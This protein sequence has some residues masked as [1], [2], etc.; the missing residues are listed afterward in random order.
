M[1]TIL[2]VIPN[3]EIELSEIA[4]ALGLEGISVSGGGPIRISDADSHGFM[5]LIEDVGEDCV[6]EDWDEK[7]IPVACAVFALDYRDK[8]F[9]SNITRLL[10]KRLGEF[11]ID[12]NNEAIVSSASYLEPFLP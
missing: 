5:R 6:F 4:K 8:R 7:I 11:I 12:T 10:N 2:L 1:E 3:P 9:V